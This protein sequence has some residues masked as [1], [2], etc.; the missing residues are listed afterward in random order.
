MAS[1]RPASEMTSTEYDCAICLGT[2]EFHVH[3]CRNGHLFCA[4]C[5]LEHTE[6]RRGTQCPTCRVPLPSEPI[7]NLVAERAIARRPATCVSASPESLGPL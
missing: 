7:R 5:L 6:R 3:Q 2:P 4:E 1:T